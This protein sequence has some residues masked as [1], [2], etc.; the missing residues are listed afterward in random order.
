MNVGLAP[1]IV[2]TLVTQEFIAAHICNIMY[3]LDAK[4]FIH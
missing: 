4:Q 3:K 2:I 1:P